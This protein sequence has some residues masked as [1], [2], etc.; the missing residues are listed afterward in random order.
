MSANPAEY[1][2]GRLLA[3]WFGDTR[4]HPDRIPARLDWWF[5]VDAARD[6]WLADEYGAVCA[7]TVAGER[8]GAPANARAWLAEIILL[9][10]LPRNLW[11]GTARAFAG[12]RLALALTLQGHREG[13]DAELTLIER[14]FFWMPLQHS[15][16]RDVQEIGVE[17]YASLAAAD[18][19]RAKL[20]NGF[21]D[22]ARRHRDLIARFGRF[23]HRNA[24]LGRASTPEEKDYLAGGGETF[25]Q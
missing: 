22:F 20:W 8:A 14:A 19:Y 1:R 21:A 25:G 13:R 24:A 12:D 15:E 18:P 7:A 2:P 3:H 9:D 5:S 10:Q 6:R 23:P 11:R 16:D 17:L 4:E